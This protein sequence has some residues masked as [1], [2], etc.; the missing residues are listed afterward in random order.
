MSNFLI[1]SLIYL[2]VSLLHL[3]SSVVPSFTGTWLDSSYFGTSYF[4]ENDD[5]TLYGVFEVYLKC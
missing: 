4:C 3:A 1:F 5:G 2:W